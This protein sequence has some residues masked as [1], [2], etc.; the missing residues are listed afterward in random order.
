M[1]KGKLQFE[2]NKQKICALMNCVRLTKANKVEFRSYAKSYFTTLPLFS[3][4]GGKNIF[5]HIIGSI[6]LK[7]TL[8]Q[9]C[10]W[11]V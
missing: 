9:T 4:G 1:L 7:P 11:S 8:L 3:M 2:I 6:A 5:A 10:Q